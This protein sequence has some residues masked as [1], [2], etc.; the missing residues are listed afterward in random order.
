ML[1]TPAINPASVCCQTYRIL[2]AI[3]APIS[4]SEVLCY[5]P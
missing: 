5:V 4:E 1:R 3:R 2:R